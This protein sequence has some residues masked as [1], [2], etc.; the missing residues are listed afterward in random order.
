MMHGQKNIKLLIHTYDE[1]TQQP[2]SCLA[3]TY[4]QPLIPKIYNFLHSILT[5]NTLVQTIC[6]VHR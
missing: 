5:N 2:I 4:M 1:E 6:D 3:S